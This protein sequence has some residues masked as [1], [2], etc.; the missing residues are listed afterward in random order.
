[1]LNALADGDL[2]MSF[3][4][5]IADWTVETD[6]TGLETVTVTDLDLFEISFVVNPGLSAD[7]GGAAVSGR[8]ARGQTGLPSNPMTRAT[9]R[10]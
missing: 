8:V 9:E 4:F 10:G 6:S 5:N 1:M 3:G 7:E 2:R